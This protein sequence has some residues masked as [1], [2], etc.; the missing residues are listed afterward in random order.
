[1]KILKFG[2][3]ILALVTIGFSFQYC[4]NNN[5]KEEQKEENV[6]KPLNCSILLDLSDRLEREMTPSQMQ[7]DTAIV[8]FIIDEFIDQCRK[9][10]MQ[11]T[12]NHLQVFFYPTPD[13][14]LVSDLAADLNIDLEKISNPAD[15]KKALKSM[16][17]QFDNSLDSIYQ[18]T[19]KMKKWVGCD[20]WSFFSNKKV[21][22]LCIRK[23]Y[24]NILVILTDG[25]LFHEKNKQV[26]GNAYSYILKETLQIPNSTLIA[27]RKGLQ[28]LEVLILE[29]NPYSPE[30]RDRLIEVLEKWLTDMEVS[31]YQIEETDIPNNIKPIISNF[32]NRTF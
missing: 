21:D 1:M 19:L 15:K 9:D 12:K 18:N 22:N 26:D 2:L 7:R 10:K 23:G 5:Q 24:R 16:K 4:S 8:N 13:N 30:Q 29:V 3:G 14:P 28:D 31:K 6:Y 32:L 25:Y 20:I 11:V 17:A 27:K